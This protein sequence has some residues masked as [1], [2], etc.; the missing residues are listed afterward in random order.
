MRNFICQRIRRWILWVGT[1]AMLHRATTAKKTAEEQKKVA[2]QQ[3]KRK[4]VI[5]GLAALV[6]TTLLL[7]LLWKKNT[8]SETPKSPD[9]LKYDALIQQALKKSEK[10]LRMVATKN[11][12]KERL[13]SFLLEEDGK[14]K[15]SY[16]YR[17]TSIMGN[18]SLTEET[19]ID[20]AVIVAKD[21]KD[22]IH[23][24]KFNNNV[25]MGFNSRKKAYDDDIKKGTNHIYNA[26]KEADKDK[27]PIF[28]LPIDP[29]GRLQVK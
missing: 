5:G 29:D 3:N 15:P 20:T 17:I 18:L 7:L 22:P 2:S 11:K 23:L 4:V 10:A 13:K 28:S 14:D 25:Y 16:S 19:L 12:N 6:G 27:P 8:P 1:I 9:E 24:F 21:Y 26:L